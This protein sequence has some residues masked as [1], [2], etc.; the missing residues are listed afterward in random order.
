MIPGKHLWLSKFYTFSV[1]S[2][3]KKISWGNMH[4][5]EFTMMFSKKCEARQPAPNATDLRSRYLRAK[6]TQTHMRMQT[7]KHP[8]LSTGIQSLFHYHKTP[9][10]SFYNSTIFNKRRVLKPS[11]VYRNRWRVGWSGSALGAE[12]TKRFLVATA[13]I[14]VGG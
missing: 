12:H 13:E 10:C 4:A 1:T 9:Y 5:W 7:L 8:F 14:Q 6:H 3:A 11:C 2:L